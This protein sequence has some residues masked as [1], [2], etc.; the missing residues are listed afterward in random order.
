M[1]GGKCDLKRLCYLLYPTCSILQ[2]KLRKTQIECSALGRGNCYAFHNT[3]RYLQQLKKQPTGEI[4]PLSI[5]LMGPF[6][7]L[8]RM[9]EE[10][11]TK[12]CFLTLSTSWQVE[13]ILSYS[14]NK[15]SGTYWL[16]LE[17]TLSNFDKYII[18]WLKCKIFEKFTWFQ[19]CSRII[20][21]FFRTLWWPFAG[22]QILIY[23]ETKDF[24]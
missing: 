8:R 4:N 9:Y 1:S 18:A 13:L 21:K 6:Q 23:V 10:S 5:T 3:T 20:S 19:A 7:L 17:N 22:P 15:L 14:K 12:T 16:T 11:S 24:R 2:P